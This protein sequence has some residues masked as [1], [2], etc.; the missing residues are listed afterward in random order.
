MNVA[1]CL[2]FLGW[3]Y[4]KELSKGLHL[5]VYAHFR[6][7]LTWK[8]LPKYG[9]AFW[10]ASTTW[11]RIHILKSHHKSTG[12]LHF[13]AF[14]VLYN[15]TAAPLNLASVI[16]PPIGD[17]VWCVKVCVCVAVGDE[18]MKAEGVR[19]AKSH[20][21]TSWPWRELSKG[22]SHKSLES[23]RH[24]CQLLRQKTHVFNSKRLGLQAVAT[25]AAVHDCKRDG[26]AV[27]TARA[28]SL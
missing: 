14:K 23:L 5:Y 13:A 18:T 25:S 17:S 15:L 6:P 8:H 4:W 11:V 12:S 7:S 26:S 22:T 10:S 16:C 28:K 2:L 9:T 27:L 3:H 1:C 20:I 21:V 19:L 24:I